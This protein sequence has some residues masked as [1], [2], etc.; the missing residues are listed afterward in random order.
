MPPWLYGLLIGVRECT[1][2]GPS[3][4]GSSYRRYQKF[5]VAINE[6]IQKYLL[7]VL[8]CGA[9]LMPLAGSGK[10]ARGPLFRTEWI[11]NPFIETEEITMYCTGIS[12]GPNPEDWR[13]WMADDTESFAGDFWEL[14]DPRPL[15]MPGGWVEEDTGV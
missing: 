13:F 12:Y 1:L 10:P 9:D 4:K 7:M 15:W 14:V 3:A 5:D 11:S 6:A 8:T 2:H